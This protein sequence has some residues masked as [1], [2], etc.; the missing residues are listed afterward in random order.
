MV[1]PDKNSNG[2]KTVDLRTP[3]SSEDVLALKAGDLVSISGNLIT[4]RDKIH[5][6]LTEQK[7]DKKDIPFDLSGAVLYH[8]GPLIKKTEDGYKIIS[9]GPTT[10][11]RLEM[12]EASV[13]KEYN[14]K[15]IIGKGGMGEKTLNALKENACV[16]FQA[17]GGAGVYLADRIK[18]VLG[19][20]KID[21]FGPAEAMWSL[22]AE[23]FPAIVTMDAHGNDIHRKIENM[24]SKKFSE[25]I[26]QKT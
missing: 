3:L 2:I 20:W 12:Y 16:Y 17:I 19:V 14:L 5:K 24:S 4:G 23:G 7:P 25:L 18:T 22:E 13:I 8:C 10:S 15:G 1:T 6:Y 21:E 9:A 11:M 26:G